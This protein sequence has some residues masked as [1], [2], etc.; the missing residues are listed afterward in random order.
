M[1]DDGETERD[2]GHHIFSTIEK[3]P[4]VWRISM[5]AAGV[6]LRKDGAFS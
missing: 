5:K 3:L 4:V 2:K 1:H 6:Y